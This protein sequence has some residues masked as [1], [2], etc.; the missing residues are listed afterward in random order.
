MFIMGL[1]LGSFGSVILARLQWPIQKDSL[2]S[3]LLGRSQCPSCKH[4]LG[5]SELVPLLSFFLQR[6]RC[7][8]CKQKI[9]WKYPLLECFSAL[10]FVLTYLT[11]RNLGVESWSLMIFWMAVN[12]LFLMLFFYDIET[13]ELHITVWVIV[14]LLILVPQFLNSMGNYQ[15]AVIASLV[16]G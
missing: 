5:A 2:K 3:V 16:F 11:L 8:H 7:R 1:I 13:L 14:F 12:W 9:A 10:V 6:R 15:H 4:T